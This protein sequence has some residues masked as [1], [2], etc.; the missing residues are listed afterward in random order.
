MSEFAVVGTNAR[1]YDGVEKVTGAGKYTADLNPPGMLLGRI[2][3]SPHPH[4]RIVCIDVSRALALPGVK[5]CVTGAEYA[6]MK[7][8][9]FPSTRDQSLIAIDKVR[10]VG[11]EVVG[12]AAFDEDTAEEALDLIDVEY[13]PLPAVFT[14]DEAMKEGAPALHEAFPNNVGAELHTEYGDVEAGFRRADHVRQ[15]TF[16]TTALAHCQMEP[17]AVLCHYQNGR[18]NVWAPNT[19]VFARR[20]AL[21]NALG[22][23]LNQVHVH[24]IYTGGAFGGRSETFPAD[25]I[26]AMLSMKSNR[27]VK[28]GLSREESIM[29]TRQKHEMRI[30]VKS[31]AKK[32]GTLV[33]RHFQVWAGGGAYM[34]TGPIAIGWPLAMIESTFRCPNLKYE[35]YRV[36]TNRP[37]CGAM[38]GHGGQQLHFAD[39]CNLERLAQDLGLD[40]VDIRLRNAVQAGE[41]LPSG[42]KITSCGLT[43]TLQRVAEE[44]GFRNKV[45]R[46]RHLS[47][48]V[49]IGCSSMINGFNMGARS[50]SQAYVKF[51]EDGSATVFSGINDTG[52]GNETAAVQVAAEELGLPMEKIRLVSSDTDLTPQDPGSYSMSSTFI[53]VNG[54]YQA[55]ADARRQL[56]KLAAEH[57]ECN[58]EDLVARNGVISVQG[59]PGTSVAIEKVIWRAWQRGKEIV[60]SGIYMPKLNLKRD[61]IAPG[62]Q[63]G[64]VTGAYSFGAVAVEVEVNR[65][66]GEVTI[67][68]ITAAHDLGRA[69]NPKA[70]E[71]QLEG[72][73]A[74]GIGQALYE[75]LVWDGGMNLNP[76]LLDYKYPTTQE[77][78]PVKSILVE[79]IDPEG[80]FGAKEAAE[81]IG[82]A[83]I[84]ATV[85]AVADAIGVQFND[86]PLTP[87]RILRALEGKERVNGAKTNGARKKRNASP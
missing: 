72:F 9:V 30:T 41:V 6:G 19:S 11:E 66:T 54:V 35:G 81:T 2:L 39:S 20:R 45:G 8:G 55:A 50:G 27:P 5:V 32:D 16:T 74:F 75:G 18:L 76:T 34:S 22:L 87:A 73:L 1:K 15:D 36:Y 3:R 17:Y 31:G 47:R 67:L 60:G 49:G 84:S 64:Q 79:S 65:D 43:E 29:T 48:G 57:L 46:Q 63:T 26:A 59:S 77:M 61:W 33:A 28:I 10:Y 68:D 80:P 7:F 86:L 14:I 78:P 38:R 37:I 83:V 69:L 52:Q 58:P 71:G 40:A 24:K 42:S 25:W 51:N 62:M 53:S 70:A 21:S 56:F 85:N 23:E 13:E 4:A 82:L 44:S 12:V